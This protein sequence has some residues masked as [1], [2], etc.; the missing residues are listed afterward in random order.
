M[1]TIDNMHQGVL[2]CFLLFSVTGSADVV[3]FVCLLYFIYLLE[4]EGAGRG[5]RACCTLLLQLPPVCMEGGLG[6]NLNTVK[7]IVT[8]HWNQTNLRYTYI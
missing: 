1:I 7:R 8:L 3:R 2:F 5:V 6:A 4:G